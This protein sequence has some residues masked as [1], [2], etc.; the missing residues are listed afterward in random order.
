MKDQVPAKRGACHPW[1]NQIYIESPG[2]TRYQRPLFD[3]IDWGPWFPRYSFQGLLVSRPPFHRCQYMRISVTFSPLVS[4]NRAPRA[5]TQSPERRRRN[6]H[7][8]SAANQGPAPKIS[9]D[10]KLTSDWWKG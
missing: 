6:E 4:Q 9:P 8:N 5:S 7:L 3:T 10:V 2:S 1:T